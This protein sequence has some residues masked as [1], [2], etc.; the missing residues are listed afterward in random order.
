MGIGSICHDHADFG[1]WRRWFPADQVA[2][3]QA[4]FLDIILYSRD[5]LS[6]EYDAMPDAKGDPALLPRAPWGIISIKAQV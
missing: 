2:A 1:T 5:Q 4:K 3:P 6:N